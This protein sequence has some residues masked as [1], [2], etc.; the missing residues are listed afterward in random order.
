MS[1]HSQMRQKSLN[2]TNN[3]TVQ[4][5]PLWFSSEVP[6][7][8]RRRVMARMRSKGG[9]W[10]F[11]FAQGERAVLRRR[12]P[13]LVS[14][15]AERHRVVSYSTIPGRWHNSVTPYSVG[16]MDASFHDAVRKIGI[17]KCPQSGIT[18]AIH[19]CIGYA[20]DRS[21]GP[22]M[23]VYPDELTAR[24]NAKDRIIPMIEGSPRLASYLSRS[25]DDRSSLR[26]NLCHMPIFLAWSGSAAR[27]GNKPIR[28]L[29]LDELDKY[30]SSKNE[31]SAEALAEKRTITWRHKARIWKISTPTVE[32]VGIW[33]YMTREAQGIFDYHVRCPH[34]GV[35]Q[36]MEFDNII[37][38]D[39]IRNPEEVAARQLAEY[40]CMHCGSLWN[41]GD[42]D[43]AVRL[44]AWRERTSG[45]ELMAHLDA[46]R[47]A[48]IGFHLPAWLSYFVS[49]SK[50]AASFLRWNASKKQ[51]DLKDFC[52]NIKAEPWRIYRI[53]R[54]E[55]RILALCDDR[56]RGTVPSIAGERG[57]AADTSPVAALVAGIDTQGSDEQKGYFRYVI[58]AFGW[59][60]TDES[61]LIQCGTVT[62]F[63]ALA[64]VLW[65]SVYRDAL[66]NE[67]RV[68]LAL[69]DAMGHRTKDVY[70]FCAANKGRIFPTQ[71]KQHQSAPLMYSPLEY[72]PGTQR[73]IPGGLRLLKVDTTFFK[74]DL[75]AKLSIAS[76]DPGAFHLHHDTPLEYA[77]E[78][79]AEFYDEQKQAWLCPDGKANHFW[80]CEVLALA[81]AFALNLRQWK[82]P[83][84]E[85]P[86]QQ[87]SRLQHSSTPHVGGR[88]SWWGGM[89]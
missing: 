57:M 7:D 20:M 28:Y 29:V 81:A 2:K 41:D 55:D 83:E 23:Y 66:G 52:N 80:D 88:P 34:C 76:E 89:R 1:L 26:I 19:N 13:M 74:N 79:T 71:G 47:P 27:L 65:K 61:W 24:E 54:S 73:R 21:P 14:K 75:A 10:R 38:P 86:P 8:V 32:H 11:R 35:E 45:L 59:G 9:V 16:I 30:Q 40:L 50:V 67:F 4:Q 70:A 12:T 6:S 77:R 5:V 69:Q 36:V 82:Q 51:E 56:P 84:V 68:R 39:T 37:W 46:F 63:D 17:C 62:S 22:V 33:Q 85:V 3:A 44:G 87:Q 42:R 31:A 25:A 18:E 60:E 49:L 48:N 43:R 72:F 15:W 58:R 53:E 64:D 78:M